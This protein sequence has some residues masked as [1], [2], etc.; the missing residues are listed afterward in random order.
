MFQIIRERDDSE[1]RNQLTSSWNDLESFFFYYWELNSLFVDQGLWICPS[2][3]NRKFIF[4][5]V[6]RCFGS[7]TFFFFFSFLPKCLWFTRRL[8][9]YQKFFFFSFVSCQKKMCRICPL[10]TA[11]ISFVAH[12]C[13]YLHCTRNG[14]V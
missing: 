3:M 2:V 14:G 10:R 7:A 8:L 6:V 11:P 9:C 5:V 12:F 13:E 4:L 1:F